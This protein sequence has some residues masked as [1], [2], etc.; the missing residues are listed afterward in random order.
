M[1]IIIVSI[2]GIIITVI[3]S[4]I[5]A[6]ITAGL[7]TGK[8]KEK[9]D[10]LEKEKTL[11]N[12]KIDSI[13][14]EVDRLIEFKANAQKFMDSNIYK[15]NS[16]LSLTEYGQKIIDESGFVALFDSEKDAL[17]A[18]LEE[19]A[20]ATKYDIQEKARELMSEL[21]D[22]QPFQFIKTN[23]FNK[24]FDYAQILRAGAILLRDY[25]FEKHPEI[26]A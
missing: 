8:Y 6:L 3:I 18:K 17:V 11:Q 5:T 1:N 16:P 23:A 14:R 22:Y 15:S 7:N 24:G 12:T 21:I 19:K 25:Y 9:V 26:Q 13:T 20:P 2:I 10:H 4:I